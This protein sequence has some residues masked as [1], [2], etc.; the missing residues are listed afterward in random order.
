M[1]IEQNLTSIAKSLELIAT[2]LTTTQHV[3]TATPQAPAQVAAPVPAKPDPV[4][5]VSPVVVPAQPAQVMP[6]VPVF[7]PAPAPVVT[8]APAPAAPTVAGPTAFT[9]K[10]AMMDFVI[11]SYKA[12]GAEKGAKIQDVLVAMGYQNINDVD[13]ARWGE[14]KNGIEALK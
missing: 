10:Q 12:L 14:L 7:T 5:T 6:P 3:Q 1:S 2:Y 9:D 4:V 11:A 8:A 13:P